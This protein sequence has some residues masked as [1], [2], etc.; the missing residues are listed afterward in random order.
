MLKSFFELDGVGKLLR[1]PR[2]AEPQHPFALLVHEECHVAL[3]RAGAGRNRDLRARARSVGKRQR[4]VQ[5][6]KGASSAR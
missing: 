5:R 1:E 4:A 2:G 6:L 3:G